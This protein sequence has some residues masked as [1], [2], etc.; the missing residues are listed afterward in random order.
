MY[1]Y[2]TGTSIKFIKNVWKKLLGVVPTEYK[3]HTF[4]LCYKITQVVIGN[5]YIMRI[6]LLLFQV[7]RL[8]N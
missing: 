7:L 3:T 6:L 2:I 5:Y 1:Y 4:I 8:S